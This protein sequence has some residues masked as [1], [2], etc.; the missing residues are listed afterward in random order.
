MEFYSDGQAFYYRTIHFIHTQTQISNFVNDSIPRYGPLGPVTIIHLE[1]PLKQFRHGTLAKD[2]TCWQGLQLILKLN[3]GSPACVK[4]DTAIALVEHR[5][6]INVPQPNP[7]TGLNNDTGI[8]TLRNH[9]YY[10]ETPNYTETAYVHPTQISFHDVTFTLFPSGF[11]GGLPAWGCGG[12]YYW[13]DAK[14]SD[15]ASELLQIFV[16]SKDCFLPQ[17][18]TH[19]STHTNPQAGL[20]FYNGKMKLLVSTSVTNSTVTKELPASFMPCDTPFPKSDTGIPVLYMPANSVGKLCVRY[21]NY[22][23]FSGSFYGG[24]RI[25]DPNNSYQSVPDVTTWSNLENTTTIQGGESFIVTY[26]IKTGN[27]TGFY[28]LNLFCGGTPFAI[29]YDNSSK[30]VSSDFPFVGYT[31][32]CPVILYDTKIDSMTGIGIKYIPYPLR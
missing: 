16:G 18:S 25:F 12:G 29:G 26:W 17:P 4:P 9:A 11:R 23:G 21:T 1:S 10:F 6:A 27:H 15:G 32:S 8:A 7:V 24:I 19:F 13:A 22:N 5:W 28:G 20:T 2:V 3:D 14:F 30:L 31:H